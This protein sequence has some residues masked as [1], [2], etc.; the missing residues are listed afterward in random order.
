M[1]VRQEKFRVLCPKSLLFMRNQMIVVMIK[2]NQIASK[3]GSERVAHK[4][5]NQKKQTK[6]YLQ[7]YL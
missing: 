5:R 1:K 6:I 7:N 2:N 4:L 3:F